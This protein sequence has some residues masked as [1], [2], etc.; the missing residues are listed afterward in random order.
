MVVLPG[1]KPAPYR[2]DLNGDGRVDGGDLGRMS[3]I[4]ASFQTSSVSVHW[5]QIARNDSA[6][7][8]GK[9][10]A[11]PKIGEAGAAPGTRIQ[12][13]TDQVT[14]QFPHEIHLRGTRTTE[15]RSAAISRRFGDIGPY[16]TRLG[17]RST[18][19]HRPVFEIPHQSLH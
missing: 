10:Q 5:K 11:S 16:A 14:I 12:T 19:L 15:A 4:P 7:A 18:P 17:R 8:V 1:G 9:N 13:S 3:L 6:P 2:G